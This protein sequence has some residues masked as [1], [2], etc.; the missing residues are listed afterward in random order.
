MS[1]RLKLE[2]LPGF[3]EDLAALPTQELRKMV[4]GLLVEVA[5]G[6]LAGRALDDRVSTGD[7]G[8]CFKLYFDTDTRQKPRFRLVYRIVAGK[9]KAVQAVAAGE[10]RDLAA[11]VTA[12]HRLGRIQH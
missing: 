5:N 9:V 2:A 10:R 1:S 7:L 6:S 4:L 11:Y 3:S 12:A 8:D